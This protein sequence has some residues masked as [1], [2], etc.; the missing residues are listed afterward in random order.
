[1]FSKS[2]KRKG[3]FGIHYHK[4]IVDFFVVTCFGFLLSICWLHFNDSCHVLH[5]TSTRKYETSSISLEI[6]NI[7]IIRK[8]SEI[9]SNCL[10]QVI[11]EITI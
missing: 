2:D 11:G 8:L 6:S 3:F 4:F 7:E 10:T 5:C 9:L 1:M